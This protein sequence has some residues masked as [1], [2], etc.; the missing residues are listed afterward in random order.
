R[1]GP[2]AQL[3]S[4]SAFQQGQQQQQQQRQQQLLQRLREQLRIRLGDREQLQR[5]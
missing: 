4:L 5:E 3:Q 1:R 2:A